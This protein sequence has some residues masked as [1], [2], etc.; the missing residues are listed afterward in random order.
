MANRITAA[1]VRD[2]ST[3][4]W[5]WQR[6]KDGLGYGHLR[7]SGRLEKAH[8]LAYETFKGQIPTGLEI[9]HL[10]RTRHCVNPDHLEAVTHQE[11]CRRAH[12]YKAR[13]R[14]LAKCG[15]PFTYFYV[16]KNGNIKRECKLCRTKRSKDFG[17]L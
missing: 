5:L 11:N 3:G 2:P 10:C 8:R 16:R 15:H 9:D 12:Q 13:L 7:V 17:K 14:T 1:T 4:C 6:S